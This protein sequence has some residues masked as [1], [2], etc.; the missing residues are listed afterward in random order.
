MPCIAGHMNKLLLL[1]LARF[2][3]AL[4]YVPAKATNDTS[5]APQAVGQ[6]FSDASS[7]T[8]QWDSDTFVKETVSFELET[9]D[10]LRVSEVCAQLL[11]RMCPGDS[12]HGRISLGCISSFF[13]EPITNRQQYVARTIS[14]YR[15]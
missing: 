2:V 8:V 14:I 5:A 11:T 3:P 10:S 4:A 9:V 7:L 6:N 12:D 13:G 15:E 1:L